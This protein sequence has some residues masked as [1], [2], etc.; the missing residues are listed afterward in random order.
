MILG[1]GDN[2]DLASLLQLKGE[3]E[4]DLADEGEKPDANHH[5][6]ARQC[7]H[8]YHG[9]LGGGDDHHQ[10]DEDGDNGDDRSTIN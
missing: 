9:Y 5:Q 2:E 10:P 6:P 1:D 4:K 3:S 7:H 8:G